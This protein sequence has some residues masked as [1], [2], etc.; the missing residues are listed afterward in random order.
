MI[1]GEDRS[2]SEHALSRFFPK[3]MD[4]YER[5]TTGENI[6]KR[7]ATGGGKKKNVRRVG[8]KKF[9]INTAILNI[10]FNRESID[11]LT[12]DITTP[13]RSHAR[14]LRTVLRPLPVPDTNT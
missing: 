9:S 14:I 3:P 7:K 13:E 11:I 5:P 4:R 6:Q 8:K 12:M 2:N 10:R 1:A